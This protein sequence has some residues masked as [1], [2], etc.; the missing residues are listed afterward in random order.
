MECVLT[1]LIEICPSDS[2]I[3]INLANIIVLS[4]E[5]CP[6]NPNDF[7]LSQYRPSPSV[8][9]KLTPSFD[10]TGNIE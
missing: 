5:I 1:F 6:T 2:T 8:I 9:S 10:G 3:P 7:N 4:L